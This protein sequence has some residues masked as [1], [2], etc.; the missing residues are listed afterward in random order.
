M[1]PG[2]PGDL[3]KPYP[4]AAAVEADWSSQSSLPGLLAAA[5]RFAVAVAA[6]AVAVVAADVVVGVSGVCRASVAVV[7]ESQVTWGVFGG[8][9]V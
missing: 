7:S 2:L 8:A 4:Q 5:V 9:E 6:V 1:K 3:W